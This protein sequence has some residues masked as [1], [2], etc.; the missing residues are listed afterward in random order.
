MTLYNGDIFDIIQLSNDQRDMIASNHAQGG[1]SV[2]FSLQDVSPELQSVIVQL[3][4]IHQHHL[5][6]VVSIGWDVIDLQ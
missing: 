4:R 6:R 1:R 2:H 5:F 3:A